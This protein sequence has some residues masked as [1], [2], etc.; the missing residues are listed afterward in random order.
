MCAFSSFLHC[1]RTNASR[2]QPSHAVFDRTVRLHLSNLFFYIYAYMSE[3]PLT[4]LIC[5]FFKYVKIFEVLSRLLGSWGYVKV[6]L[7]VVV[8]SHFILLLGDALVR[9]YSLMCLLLK[10]LTLSSNTKSPHAGNFMYHVLYLMHQFCWGILVLCLK[11]RSQFHLLL[12][13][14]T[15][16][17]VSTLLIPTL[18]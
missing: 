4:W 8:M 14:I 17:Q 1:P 5:I 18:W 2:M 10:G 9:F 6:T 7:Q 12:Y 11:Y 13:P 15:L 3:N 16:S